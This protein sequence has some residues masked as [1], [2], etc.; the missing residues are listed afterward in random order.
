MRAWSVST[1]AALSPKAAQ[2]GKG[3][4]KR[5]DASTT[6]TP[7]AE[8]SPNHLR[9]FMVPP[10]QRPRPGRS[11]GVC[12]A[13][14]SC[15]FDLTNTDSRCFGLYKLS[16]RNIVPPLSIQFRLFER[17]GCFDLVRFPRASENARM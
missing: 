1:E 12:E 11:S 17:I 3:S 9:G 4:S 2:A 6:P 5:N 14:L 7:F 8:R 10:P 16:M 15:F 13:Q